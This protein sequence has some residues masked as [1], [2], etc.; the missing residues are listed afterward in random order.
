MAEEPWIP[1]EE[2]TYPIC[3][4]LK[5][6]NYTYICTGIENIWKGT[7]KKISTVATAGGPLLSTLHFSLLL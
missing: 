4:F 5:K 6:I 7:H 1:F 2:P 3:G